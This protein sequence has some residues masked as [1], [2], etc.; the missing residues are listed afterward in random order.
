MKLTSIFG[1][2]LK[3]N[4]GATMVLVLTL[5]L[6]CVMVSSV[7]LAAASSGASRNDK[8]AK[9]QNGYLAVSSATDLV[10]EELKTLGVFVGENIEMHYGCEDCTVDGYIDYGGAMIQG[11]RLEAEY[12]GDKYN[13]SYE[14]NP[15]DD[16][17]L[18]LPVTHDI[19]T[20]TIVDA[21]KTTLDGVF[22]EMFKRACTQVFTT[23]ADYTE[24][25]KLSLA[26]A[27]ERLPE[28]TCLFKMS[29][30]YNVEFTLS[31]DSSAYAITITAL[32]II[33][34][35]DVKET[36]D[37]SDKHTIY[38]KKFNDEK[39]NYETVMVSDWVIPID[40]KT[41]TTE[42]SWDEPK[43]EKEVLSQ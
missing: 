9:Q 21:G 30:E 12:A 14:A 40:V 32:G 6:V 27:D 17:H 8:R 31:T 23:D 35:A 16:G 15:L 2:K 24:I 18:M 36:V 41:T 10:L 11:K 19:H 20:K 25:V 7:L 39:G 28:V 29:K 43:V 34:E 37:E 38:Y 4:R 26:V 13:T 5:F 3:S 33:K 42:V 1:K 22:A